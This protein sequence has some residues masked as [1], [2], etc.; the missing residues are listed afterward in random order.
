MSVKPRAVIRPTYATRLVTF[1]HPGHDSKSSGTASTASLPATELSHNVSQEETD[2]FERVL[3]EDKGAQ[4]RAPWMRDGSDM[5]PVSRPRSAGA[6]TKG[7]FAMMSGQSRR[8]SKYTNCLLRQAPDN[9]ITYAENHPA[10][11]DTGP[12]HGPQRY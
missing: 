2:E 12:K 7:W 10:P 11:H 3:A 9:P 8:F 4:T 5:P 1:N 6:M